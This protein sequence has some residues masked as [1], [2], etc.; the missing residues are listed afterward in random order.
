MWG[1]EGG[2]HLQ[3]K[4][5]SNSRNEHGA[6]YA[7]KLRFVSSCKYTHSVV[8][9]LSWLHDT[10]PCVLIVVDIYVHFSWQIL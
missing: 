9:R 8:C 2:E 10:L 1:A 5:Y 3:C 7:E 6:M 4:N